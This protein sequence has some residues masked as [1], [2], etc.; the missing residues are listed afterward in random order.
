MP[1][2][3]LNGNEGQNDRLEL[4]NGGKKFSKIFRGKL[5]FFFLVAGYSATPGCHKSQPIGTV[6][7]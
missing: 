5:D 6:V 3:I 7:R 4:R 1:V 2:R